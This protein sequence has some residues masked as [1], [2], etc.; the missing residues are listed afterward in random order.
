M[1]RINFASQN[2]WRLSSWLAR[3]EKTMVKGEK[4]KK[5]TTDKKKFM[6]V[7]PKI[8]PPQNPVPVTYDINRMIKLEN[9][10]NQKRRSTLSTASE[11]SI[12]DQED[13]MLE[14]YSL[15]NMS[16]I[17]D[18]SMSR[19]QS[20]SEEHLTRYIWTY[21]PVSKSHINNCY[22]SPLVIGAMTESSSS[23]EFEY[24]TSLQF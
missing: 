15:C 12:F 22:P 9:A 24:P 2:P 14:E 18:E 10:S 13:I 8:L 23:D 1:L 20:Q 16:N 7:I 11:S 4:N 19:Q 21:E 6:F 5:A 17:A 3:K